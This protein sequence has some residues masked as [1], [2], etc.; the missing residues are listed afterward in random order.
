[1]TCQRIEELLSAYLEGELAAAEKA[2]VDA[3]LGTCRECASLAGLLRETMGATAAF[4]EI[5]PSPALLSKLYAIPAGKREKKSLFRP[6]FD[7]LTRPALQPVYAAL[8]GLFIV[9][10]FVLFH[11]EGRGIRKQI[12]LRLHRG[13]GTVEKLYADA[14]AIKAEVGAFT[15]NMVKSFNSLGL[16]RGDEKKQ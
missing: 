13:I 3:H 12:D 15:G 11:P 5:E 14:G 1:M 4:S 10:S 16:L 8:T 2:E 7:Y 6:I 9:L